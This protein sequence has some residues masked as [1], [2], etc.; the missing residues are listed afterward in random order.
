MSTF[1]K[2]TALFFS[3]IIVFVAAVSPRAAAAESNTQVYKV[4]MLEYPGYAYKDSSGRV[5]GADAEYAYR[6]A[7][8]AGIKIK[9]ILYKDT[10][11]FVSKLDDGSVDML[12]NIA[13]TEQRRQNYLFSD[14][15]VGS[16]TISIYVRP[17]DDRFEY[18]NV[19][20]LKNAVFGVDNGNAA[21]D[22]FENWCA[23]RG[24]TP[25]TVS[26][27]SLSEID[28]ALDNGKID[29]G[30]YTSDKKIGYK[31][32]ANF[33]PT[34]Y[35]ILFRKDE[36]SLK[37]QIDKAMND[38]LSKDPLYE[39]KM[40]EKYTAAINT[41]MD[42]LTSAEKDYIR[43]H[44]VLKIAVVK[45]DAPYFRQDKNGDPSG[46]ITD[47]YKQI[48]ELTGLKTEYCVYDSSE[49]AA[50]AVKA[51][52]A[53]VLGI[54]SDGLVTAYND[55]LLLTNA[56]AEVDTVI[57]MRA[58]DKLS[59]AKTI[60]VKN[61]TKSQIAS[62]I[63]KTSASKLKGYKN[64][65]ECFAALS[66]EEADAVVCGLPSAT[67]F[68]NNNNSS[69]YSISVLPSSKLDLCGALAQG[70]TVLASVLDKAIS[71]SDYTFESIS[72]N[73]T[74]QEN[75]VKSFLSKISPS[76][77]IAVAAVLALMVIVLIYTLISLMNRQREKNFILA[78]KAETDR[79]K[80]EL[81]AIKKSN[82]E[83]NRFFS[84]ISH[85]M[86]TPLNAIIG[87]SDLASKENISQQTAGYLKKIRMSGELLLD[88]INDTLTISR[89]GSGKLVLHPSPVSVKEI[90][91]SVSIPVRQSAEERNIEFITD[92]SEMQDFVID[93]DKLALEKIILNLL[94][95]AVK[96]T[97]PGGNVYFSMTASTAASDIS[98]D[99]GVRVADSGIG[100][101]Q[102]FL[103]HVFEPFAQEQRSGYEAKGTGLGLSIVKELTDL[104][105][106]TIQVRSEKNMGTEFVLR[107]S[108]PKSESALSPAGLN[109]PEK[110]ADLKGKKI[111]VCEDNELNSE[112]AC[113]LLAQKG[114][115]YVTAANGQQGLEIFSESEPFE[116]SAVLMDLRMPV[117]N[118]LDATRA[119]RSA[120]RPDAKS[121][122][123]IAMTADAFDEDIRQ[124]LDAGM[125]AHIAKPIDPGT[126][127]AYLEKFIS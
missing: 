64:A 13:L 35:Y 28:E 86:R 119:I 73:N 30:I 39:E 48:S 58:G 113:S 109:V 45:N 23:S 37:S 21:T 36:T 108:F 112:I 33:S 51:G 110:S 121:I 84:D 83:K 65:S 55:G 100:I 6:I 75:T 41:E 11:Q 12:F 20:S 106:G 19:D 34:E 50:A 96:Y 8:Q 68:I 16:S 40:V 26:F 126:L 29:A 105:N 123:V 31:T 24:F 5:T 10:S 76:V 118:G 98:A 27:N 4:G 57:V 52:S 120:K 81:E 72:A 56:Y 9:I 74:I 59:Y 77:L 101:S 49:L 127:Y 91:D 97:A 25:Q 116:F 42:E 92:I 114:A 71:V 18:G 1:N 7:Q 70:N 44:P 99:I 69:R 87:F 85:D 38:I 82:D 3:L 115:L 43:N 89:A 53:D 62:V 78:E 111:L 47:Y 17:D 22:L 67:W 117:M 94:S 60:A 103:P 80:I 93:A 54:Y 104:M 14:N 107:F 66:S 61:R 95:N 125:N 79:R 102:D 122:P 124:C 32:V 46:I 90:F 15:A 88:L 2:I 63:G